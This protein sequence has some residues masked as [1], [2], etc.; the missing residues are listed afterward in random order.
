MAVACSILS[1]VLAQ[2]LKQRST[3]SDRSK[4]KSRKKRRWWVRQWIQKRKSNGG[5]M[6]ISRELQ[7]ENPE[8]FKNILRMSDTHFD[9][10]LN[11][12]KFMVQKMATT[13]HCLFVIHFHNVFMLL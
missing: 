2:Q 4:L 8:D 7:N 5:A 6:F 13:M 12:I 10:L 3:E 11:K 9:Y 1:G